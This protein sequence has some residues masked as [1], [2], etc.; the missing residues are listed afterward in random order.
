MFLK[1]KYD[2][3]GPLVAKELEKRGFDAYYVSTKE[4]AKD[5]VL[6]MIPEGSSVAWGGS[7]TLNETGIKDAIKAGN[8]TVIDRETA[9]PFTDEWMAIMR[10]ALTS[11]FFLM[12]SNAITEDGQLVNIDGLGNRVAALCFGPKEVIVVSGMNKVV[13][14]LDDAW[15]RARNFASPLNSQRYENL[16]NPC[17]VTG[18][19]SDCKSQ[20][21]ICSQFVVT[22]L[23]K[24]KRVKVVLVGED[25]GF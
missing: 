20:Q 17:V 16:A 10:Q 5:K 19:C 11:D 2:K 3:A 15:E 25:L 21:S 24:N 22:R 7:M 12:S 18:M 23:V 13:C 14:S 8:Y 1:K 9:Q 6:S 4:E